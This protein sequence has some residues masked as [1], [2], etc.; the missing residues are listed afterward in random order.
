MAVRRHG[1]SHEPHPIVVQLP[2]GAAEVVFSPTWAT[3]GRVKLFN[4]IIIIMHFCCQ[5]MLLWIDAFEWLALYATMLFVFVSVRTEKVDD[6]PFSKRWATF[7]LLI[8]ILCLF[9][10]LSDILKF[11]SWKT[12]KIIAFAISTLNTLLLLPIWLLWLGKQLKRAKVAY[13]SDTGGAELPVQAIG[14]HDSIL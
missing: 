5:G 4:I 2:R 1:I 6:P 12:F 7:G 8:A 3:R 14:E 13:D 10:F 9:D 11:Q